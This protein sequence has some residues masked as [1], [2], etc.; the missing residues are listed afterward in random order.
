MRHLID[1][2]VTRAIQSMDADGPDVAIKAACLAAIAV[3]CERE[4]S[5]AMVDAADVATDYELLRDKDIRSAYRAMLAVA[6]DEL[7]GEGK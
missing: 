1:A 6:R 5:E 4:P 7:K 2:I 3:F